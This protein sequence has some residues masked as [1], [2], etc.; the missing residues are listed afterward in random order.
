[1]ANLK[2]DLQQWSVAL[3]RSISVKDVYELA[4]RS[5][6]GRY[7]R[8]V[9]NHR[10]KLLPPSDELFFPQVR[11]NGDVFITPFD[12]TTRM[13]DGAT[14]ELCLV[15]VYDG[16]QSPDNVISYWESRETTRSLGSTVFRYYR[17]KF[18]QN[19]FTRIHGPLVVWTD[20]ANRGD[21]RYRGGPK[22][23]W[24]PLQNFFKSEHCKGQLSE[25]PL[26]TTEEDEY[27]PADR[28][29]PHVLKLYLGSAPRKRLQTQTS[30]TL[31]RMDVLKAMFDSYL[32]RTLAYNMN[33][34]MGLV[35][36]RSTAALAQQIT[37]SIENFRHELNNIT[38]SGDTACWDAIALA[39]DQLLV[40]A[41]KFPK[42]RLRILCLSDGEDNK[43]KTIVS[44]IAMKLW[45]AKIVVDSFCLG[46]A[47]N[48]DLKTISYL[49]G[50]FKFQPDTMENAM[51]ICEMEP[52][53]S[54]LERPDINLPAGPRHLTSY[55][56]ISHFNR[57][58]HH[59]TVDIV[60]RDVFPKRRENP[61]LSESFVELGAFTRKFDIAKRSDGNLRSSR[62][63]SEMRNAGAK[64][65]PYY[66]I[67][68]CESNMGLWKVVMQ[69]PPG[70]A[71][72][73]GVFLLYLE[74][75]EG[76]P[77]FAPSSRFVTLVYHPNIN[78]HG[79]VRTHLSYTATSL[80]T[81]YAF[82]R[83]VT[84]S[85]TVTGPLIRH[86]RIF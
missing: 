25:E 52:V 50:G 33:T 40:Y 85:S 76:Y 10:N 24:E 45:Q 66:D 63:L 74:M 4:F 80:L 82:S 67:Y 11:E 41:A 77:A 61:G 38:A 28:S 83:S 79:K 62:L 55:G 8:F 6:K 13:A 18:L 78:V 17:Q 75:G 48:L 43:S 15:K 12:E 68:I 51:A 21:N 86:A 32:N 31:S 16:Y 7:T 20:M 64:P 29:Q 44:D 42:A 57:A 1:M 54:Q 69:G 81:C 72:E 22:D 27:T 3:P 84:V 58:K 2:S 26:C 19:R 30:R 49:T 14:K 73:T 46:Q 65:H 56:A 60:N 37:H 59:I 34:H 53:L 36:F 9:L 39:R 35:T 23:H 71:Y 5:T 70:S 47:K